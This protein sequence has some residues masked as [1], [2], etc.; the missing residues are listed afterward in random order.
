MMEWTIVFEDD[1][2]N[3]I[4]IEQRTDEPNS[5]FLERFD[6]AAKAKAYV[7]RKGSTPGA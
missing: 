3:P 7:G 6:E 2:A 5:A 4:V 1:I